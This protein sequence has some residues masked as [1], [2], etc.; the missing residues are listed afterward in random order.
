MVKGD[1]LVLGNVSVNNSSF[2]NDLVPK[3]ALSYLSLQWEGSSLHIIASK[4]IGFLICM[5]Q[6]SF[7]SFNSTSSTPP[8]WIRLALALPELV[9]SS[10]LIILSGSFSSSSSELF[11]SLCSFACFQLSFILCPLKEASYDITL[12]GVSVTFSADKIREFLGIARPK[13]TSYPDREEEIVDHLVLSNSELYKLLTGKEEVPDHLPNI[14]HSAM[15]DFFRMLHLIVEYYI[16]PRWCTSE[17]SFERVKLN[18]P[19]PPSF[20]NAS[21]GLRISLDRG[22]T[23]SRR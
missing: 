11:S 15:T 1:S 5:A 9:A 14:P 6:L 19:R 20:L 12:R 3:F 21:I 23:G 18:P 17:A 8:T 13:S 10:I 4:S 7:E 2:V 22:S 16:D